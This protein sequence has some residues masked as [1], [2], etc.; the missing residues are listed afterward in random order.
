MSPGSSVS[1][2]TGCILRVRIRDLS[3][4]QNV[5]SFIFWVVTQPSAKTNHLHISS[6]KLTCP[7]TLRQP[8]PS[9]VTLFLI[10]IRGYVE[11]RAIVQREVLCQ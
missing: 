3:L 4:L 1:L 7:W 6:V 9:G 5:Q 8:L 11:P 2:V 10:R